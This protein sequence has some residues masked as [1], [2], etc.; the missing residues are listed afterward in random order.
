MPPYHYSHN[1]VIHIIA[2]VL[3]KSGS[4]V[5]SILLRSNGSRNDV[6]CVSIWFVLSFQVW[7]RE[8]KTPNNFVM[9][10]INFIKQEVVALTQQT[11]PSLPVVIL[12]IASSWGNMYWIRWKCWVRDWYTV[13]SRLFSADNKKNWNL[14]FCQFSFSFN[15]LKV[16]FVFSGQD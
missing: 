13:Q 6:A 1:Y 15:K 7:S 10:N 11:N 5:I 14:D 12:W 2:C 3:E 8:C 16:V 9:Q 4:R